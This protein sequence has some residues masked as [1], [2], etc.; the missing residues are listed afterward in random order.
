MIENKKISLKKLQILNNDF[1]IP[2]KYY[3]PKKLID[4]IEAICK[5]EFFKYYTNSLHKYQLIYQNKLQQALYF[6]I[7]IHKFNLLKNNELKTVT[8]IKKIKEINLKYDVKLGNQISKEILTNIMT[9]RDLYKIKKILLKYNLIGYVPLF[10]TIKLETNKIKKIVSY[11]SKD[12][13]QAIHYFINPIYLDN[14]NN[15]IEITNKYA[16]KHLYLLKHLMLFGNKRK[17]LN[18]NYLPYKHEEKN[19]QYLYQKQMSFDIEDFNNK[20]MEKFPELKEI[21]DFNNKIYDILFNNKTF[22]EL[23]N[24]KNYEK[25]I[26]LYKIM[27]NVNKHMFHATEAYGRIFMPLQHISHEFRE[28]LRFGE[29]KEKIIELFDIK[30]CFVQLAGRLALSTETNKI[31]C[32]E[33]KSL[34]N[35]AKSDIYNEIL[36]FLKNK[37]L[38]RNDIKSHIMEWLFSTN[39]QRTYNTN[40]IL[41]GISY[42]FEIKFPNFYEWIINYNLQL[43]NHVLKNKKKK[44]IN[45]L[46]IDCFYYESKLMFD[47][48]LPLLHYKFPNYPFISLHDSIWSIKS[49]LKETNLTSKDFYNYIENLIDTISLK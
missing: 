16:D 2:E 20:I 46:S 25:I 14:Y 9:N 35:L 6:F 29:K 11:Y 34:I 38:T 23:K 3:L 42:F 21:K 32:N 45:K 39:I 15:L 48:I 5:L 40:E 17:G 18:E 47:Y 43:S 1:I 4:K 12:K 36:L 8:D 22:I 13:K 37:N 33:Y 27:I 7:A 19:K 49:I 28:C 10:T 26:S 31:K 24:L 41:K 30:C 44:L